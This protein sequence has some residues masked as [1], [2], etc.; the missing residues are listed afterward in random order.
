MNESILRGVL[1]A[2]LMMIGFGIG[3]TVSQDP[4]PEP[5]PRGFVVA[6]QAGITNNMTKV[7]NIIMAG[8]SFTE[9][10]LNQALAGIQSDTNITKESVVILNAIPVY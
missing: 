4:K 1:S 3:Y 9:L 6:F 10:A 5:K 8:P 2:S 7:G